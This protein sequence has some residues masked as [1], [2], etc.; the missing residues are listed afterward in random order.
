MEFT[1]FI[2]AY[3]LQQAHRAPEAPNLCP[4]ALTGVAWLWKFM[5]KHPQA[6]SVAH[7]RGKV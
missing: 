2:L 5:R 3:N 4:R 1:W 6:K 7:I